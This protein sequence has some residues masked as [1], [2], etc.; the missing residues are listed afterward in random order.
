ML[1]RSSSAPIPSS[2]LP[3]SPE[4]ELM[5]LHLPRT[6]SSVACCLSQHLSELDLHS[7]RSSKKKKK[8]RS[9]LTHSNDCWNQKKNK[10]RECDHVEEEEEARKETSVPSVRGLFSCCGSDHEVVKMEANDH[11]RKRVQQSLVLGGGGKGS[12]GGHRNR[13]DYSE[14][15][16]HGRDHTNA[17]YQ[18]MI[19]ANPDNALLL[20]NY[21]RFLKEVC[22]DYPKAEEYLERAILANPGDGNVLSLYADLIWQ[23]QKNAD[24]AEGYFEQAVK[25]SPNDCF[26]ASYAK[27]L[28]DAEEDEEDKESKKKSDQSHAC[29]LDPFHGIFNY[30]PRLP[31]AS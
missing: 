26:Q 20:G 6:R 16:N 31:A 1:L 19:E 23:T 18:K 21:A 5:I 24:R 3:H 30:H 15:G 27:F 22:G 14:G 9:G 17:Y 29:K 2:W 11:T 28:W 25:S 12:D 13:S 8:N 4:S 7:S 10:I